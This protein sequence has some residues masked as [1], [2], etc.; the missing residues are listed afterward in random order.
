VIPDGQLVVLAVRSD[1]LHLAH[2]H[3]TRSS[4]RVVHLPSGADDLPH[5]CTD[6]FPI[7]TVLVVQLAEARGVEVES[8][9]PDTD[10]SPVEVRTRI[11]P[12]C[13]LREHT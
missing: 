6:S 4:D 10:L 8:M 7:A 2:E 1:G 5:L 13:G 11:Q 9:H 12:P 3:A